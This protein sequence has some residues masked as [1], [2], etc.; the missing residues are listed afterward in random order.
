M[1]FEEPETG[2]SESRLKILDQWNEKH[3]TSFLNILGVVLHFIEEQLR[4]ENS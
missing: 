4:V 3:Y 1:N 2:V